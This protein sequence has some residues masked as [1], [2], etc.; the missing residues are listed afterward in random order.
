MPAIQILESRMDPRIPRNSS[1]GF[2]WIATGNTFSP[3]LDWRP[4]RETNFT[5]EHENRL[6]E[7]KFARDFGSVSCDGDD[8]GSGNGSVGVGVGYRGSG[9]GSVGCESSVGVSAD[10]EGRGTG[11]G[12]GSG[13][14]YCEGSGSAG[15]SG[16]VG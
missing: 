12:S 4:S 8:N 1:D 5:P 7:M 9:S 13:G 3:R 2:R 16:S 11:S 15:G 14:V 6:E 10:R